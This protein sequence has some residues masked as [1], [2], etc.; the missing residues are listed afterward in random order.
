MRAGKLRH[1]ITIQQA[2]E[3][4]DSHG[5][6]TRTWIT[7]ANRWGQVMPLRGQ[8]MLMAQQMDSRITHRI[9]LR[10]YF[11]ADATF[12]ILHK[13]RVLNIVS[14]L[15]PS[16]RNIMNEVLAREDV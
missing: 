5:G 1:R 7:Q 12:R 13:G 9:K 14:V 11:K 2:S 4:R 3:T 16:E 6:V 15:N 10:Y 8:E